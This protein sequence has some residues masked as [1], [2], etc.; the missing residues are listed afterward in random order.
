[1]SQTCRLDQNLHGRRQT[2]EEA[3]N[4]KVNA[5]QKQSVRTKMSVSFRL[6]YA[7]TVQRFMTEAETL[8]L[9][10]SD[11]QPRIICF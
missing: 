3:R 11:N 5:Q 8:L 6:R 7:Q 10:G 1:M 4:E 2:I 9:N